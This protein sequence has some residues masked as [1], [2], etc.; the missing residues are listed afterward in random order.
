MAA[1]DMT[2]MEKARRAG[3]SGTAGDDAL[4][5]LDRENLTAYLKS[6]RRSF[7]ELP[8]SDADLLAFSALLYAEFERFGEFPA[9]VRIGDL[10]E[11]GTLHEYMEHDCNPIGMMAL[12]EALVASPRFGDVRLER[13]ECIVDESCIIQFGAACF[14][15]SGEEAVVAF[16]GTDSKLV[17]WHEDFAA[18]YLEM[19]PGQVEALRYARAAAEAYPE[20]KL[21]VCGHSKGGTEAESVALFADDALASRID[22]AVS[23]DGPAL[24]KN[25]GSAAPDLEAFDLVLLERYGALTTPVTRYIF[26]SKIGLMMERRDPGV[27]PYTATVNPALGHNVCSVKVVDGQLASAEP[28][29]KSIRGALVLTRLVAG[30][31]A[32]ERQVVVEE[33]IAACRNAGVTIDLSERGIARLTKLLKAHYRTLPRDRKRIFRRLIRLALA[34]GAVKI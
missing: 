4:G 1:E 32:E 17:G 12:L 24:F 11:H 16:R 2:G 30:F 20:A 26:P 9:S 29:D 14:A 15:L 8:L 13:F 22:R 21:V 19:M 28:D 25:G 31:T 3:A 18:L 5:G 27:F 34:D 10:L 6:E 7:G 33:V 23:F